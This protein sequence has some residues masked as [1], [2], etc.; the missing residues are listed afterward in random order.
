MFVATVRNEVVANSNNFIAKTSKR[1]VFTFDR[2]VDNYIFHYHN[3]DTVEW[4]KTYLESVMN[5]FRHLK[6]YSNCVLVDSIFPRYR[7]YISLFAR[8]S[9]KNLYESILLK[10]HAYEKIIRS[11][12]VF[13]VKAYCGISL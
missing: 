12:S 9:Y 3:N 1:N 4:S 8:E 6:C 5:R 2:C 11:I 7:K 13:T 10:L